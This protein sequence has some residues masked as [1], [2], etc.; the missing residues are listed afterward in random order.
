MKKLSIVLLLALLAIGCTKVENKKI[1]KSG[2]ENDLNNLNENYQLTSL[3]D[4]LLTKLV[5]YSK[6][7]EYFIEYYYIPEDA[8]KFLVD[9]DEFDNIT[10]KLFE[11]IEETQLSYGAF[12]NEISDYELS[13]EKGKTKLDSLYIL[14]DKECLKLQSEIDS[15]NKLLENIVT[16]KLLN[17]EPFTYK[18]R[19]YISV[20]LLATNNSGKT[21]E[22]VNFN[23]KIYNK[24]NELKTTLIC[25]SSKPFSKSRKLSYE[26]EE[27]DYDRRDIYKALEQTTMSSVG[28]IEQVIKRI[29]LDGEIIGKNQINFKYKTYDNL[30]GYCPYID[31]TDDL[32][33]KIESQKYKNKAIIENFKTMNLID[34][35]SKSFVSLNA[36]Q[37]KLKEAFN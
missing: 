3:Q 5:A 30:F 9:N 23:I 6:G 31:D 21:V 36:F 33:I 12:L 1:T 14:V 8:T 18:Y 35:E 27:Y 17:I 24:L 34:K 4:S 10:S 2:I 20:S 15:T 22:A 25:T 29:N 28:K 16:F 37:Q 19:D 26:Y 13:K 7:R 32:M 11:E